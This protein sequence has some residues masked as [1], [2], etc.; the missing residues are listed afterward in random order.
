MV[1]LYYVRIKANDESIMAVLCFG[2]TFRSNFSSCYLC[3]IPFCST[4][5]GGNS[6]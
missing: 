1:N 2:A 5:S 3:I 6:F 4:S